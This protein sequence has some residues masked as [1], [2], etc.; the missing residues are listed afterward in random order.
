M[1]VWC[2][3]LFFLVE[4][5]TVPANEQAPVNIWEVRTLYAP[6]PPYPRVARER[7]LTGQWGQFLLHINRKTGAVISVVIEKSTRIRLLDESAVET[8]RRWRFERGSPAIV[9]V[10]IKFVMKGEEYSPW[11][12]TSG[13]TK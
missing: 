10:P 7:R 5:A 4:V 2:V 8:F 1:R 12:P 9:R 11:T 6:R 13:V 3:I